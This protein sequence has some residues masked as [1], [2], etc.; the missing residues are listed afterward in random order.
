MD[1][2][3]AFKRYLTDL[4]ALL[5]ENFDGKFYF[6]GVSDVGAARELFARGI[7]PLQVMM[8]LEDEGIDGRF[9]LSD[10]RNLV[11]SRAPSPVKEAEFVSSPYEKVERLRQFVIS[12]LIELDAEDRG[13]VDALGRLTEEEE[14]F[15]IEKELQK[16]EDSLFKIL[17][18]YSPHSK[19]CA[20]WAKSKLER[21]SFYWSEK[22]LELSQKALFR[23]CL[24][25]KHGIPEFTAL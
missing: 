7:D 1:Q 24:R 14:L 2:R 15:K 12:L 20:R 13:I 18:L 16:I 17:E 11:L 23:E 19:E 8:I 5:A 10:V 22:I 25:K 9:N 3:E 4:R 6:G 21:F